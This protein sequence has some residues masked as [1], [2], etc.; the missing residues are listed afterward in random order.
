MGLFSFLKK[1]DFFS[2]EEKS[3]ILDAIRAAEKATSGEIRVYVESKC[4]FV[5]PLD[6]AG[7]VF[8]GLKMDHTEE[9]NAVLVYV[10][11]RDHQFAIFADEGIYKKAGQVFWQEKVEKMKQ[12]FLDN[13][14]AE[15]MVE[16]IGDIGDSLHT[17]F[18][19]NKETDRNELPDEIVFG[20]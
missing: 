11:T 19:Y 15:A 1:T 14:V 18:P 8:W 4:R 20:R 2:E 13:Q 6:R 3:R 12:K 17:H 9:R 16:V 10:A 7:E 5:D